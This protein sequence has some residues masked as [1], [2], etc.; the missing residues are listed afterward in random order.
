MA[1]PSYGFDSMA[2]VGNIGVAL[3]TK[4]FRAEGTEV[5]DVTADTRWRERDVD[6]IVGGAMVEVKT[7][8][9]KPKNIFIELTCAGRPGCVFMSRADYWA[10]VF[11]DSGTFHWIALPELQHWICHNVGNYTPVVIR[12]HRKK[13]QWEAVG[14]CVPVTD[15]KTAGV[16][17]DTVTLHT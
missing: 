8:T 7:D 15:L 5:V 9:H 12:S 1:A 6:L 3:L 2:R 14:I 16:Y 10:V 17:V 11:P 13:A 4:H